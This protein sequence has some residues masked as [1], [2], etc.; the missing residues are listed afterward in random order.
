VELSP[1]AQAFLKVRSMLDGLAPASREDRIARIRADIASGRYAV[2][3]ERIADA[4][5]RDPGAAR[6]L[7]LAR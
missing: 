3:G 1:E 6:M 7:G 5:L 2:D 4:M